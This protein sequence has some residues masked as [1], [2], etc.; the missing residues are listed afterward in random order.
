MR[1][2]LVGHTGFV[3]S[4]IA[5]Q[6]KFDAYYNSKNIWDIKGE[7]FHTVICAGAPGLKWYA[8]ECPKR[9]WDVITSLMSALAFAKIQK[10]VLVS[11]VDAIDPV[12]AYGRNRADLEMMMGDVADTHVIRLPTLFGPGL[13]KNALFDLMHDQ[14]LEHIA[15]NAV[16]QWY[17]I[18]RLVHDIRTFQAVLPRTVAFLSEPIVME[19]IRWRF[20]PTKQIAPPRKDAPCYCVPSL[21]NF[22]LPK[23]QVL[24]EMGR[25]IDGVA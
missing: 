14:R 7:E 21:D 18:S 1:T 5:R 11:T 2:A 20:F 25:F 23:Q 19:E 8:N 3:G 24:D 9:D 10:I 4:N 13:K 12:D 15:A 6:M 16:Y 22:W 17:P